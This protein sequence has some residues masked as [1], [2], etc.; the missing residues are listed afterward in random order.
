MPQ[1]LVSAFINSN[2]EFYLQIMRRYCEETKTDYFDKQSKLPVIVKYKMVDSNLIT[3][4]IEFYNPEPD[5][6][7]NRLAHNFMY[8][9]IDKSSN[10]FYFQNRCLNHFYKFNSKTKKVESIF[11]SNCN[12]EI[13]PIWYNPDSIKREDILIKQNMVS[14]F[15]FSNYKVY[16]EITYNKIEGIIK[17]LQIISTNGK[18]LNEILLNDNTT[19]RKLGDEI[20]LSQTENG[21]FKLSSISYEN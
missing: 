1:Q 11:L 5:K 13:A 16:R 6:I 17:V 10:N 8:F 19:I 7:Y 18:I 12:Y 4:P 3:T 20:F 21:I 14:K 9:D 15:Y 2:D